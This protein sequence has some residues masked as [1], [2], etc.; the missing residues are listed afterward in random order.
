MTAHLFGSQPGEAAARASERQ[1]AEEILAAY[2]AKRARG[3][4]RPS[5]IMPSTGLIVR[6]DPNRRHLTDGDALRLRKAI[7]K[8][9]RKAQR[10]I[11][12]ELGA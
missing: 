1:A 8:R 12:Q 4:Q 6:P 10:A 11:A 2:D 3:K 9:R 7:L 5:L